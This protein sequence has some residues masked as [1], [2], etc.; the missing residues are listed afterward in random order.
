M[1]LR[2]L[3]IL[4]P[5]LSLA[6]ADVEFTSPRPGA[7]IAGTTLSIEM[8]D[9]GDTPRIPDLATY[10]MFLCAGGNEDTEYVGQNNQRK[11]PAG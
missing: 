1:I 4:A 2:I 9:T 3:S 6:V 10:Q 8:R 11:S 7:A 5:L